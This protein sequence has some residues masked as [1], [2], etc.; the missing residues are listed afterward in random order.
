MFAEISYGYPLY[1]LKYGS[2]FGQWILSTLD[3][4]LDQFCNLKF[5]LH[6]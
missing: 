6:L 2:D 4:L 3:I 1:I 5:S